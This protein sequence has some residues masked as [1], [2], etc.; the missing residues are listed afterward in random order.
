VVIIGS[1]STAMPTAAGS[2]QEGQAQAPVQQAGVFLMVAIGLGLGQAGQQDG[3][4]RHAQ[5]GGRE[6]HQAVGIRQPG[7]AALG[8]REAMLVLI[9]RLICAAETAN[10]AGPIF[11]STRR[12]PG[13]DRPAAGFHDSDGSMPIDQRRDLDRHLQHA[14]HEHGN[15]HGVDR[16]FQVLLQE[17][18]SQDGGNIQQHRREGGNLEL[19]PG[20]EHAAGH[21]HEGH[22]GNVREHQARHPHGRVELLRPLAIA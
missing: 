9:I 6:F 21:G 19:A 5:Q 8:Q 2:Q 7:D 14:A 4:Q 18:R 11:F 3:A 15:G 20:V 17:Q 10:T 13:S 16:L 22:E 1:A 12:T